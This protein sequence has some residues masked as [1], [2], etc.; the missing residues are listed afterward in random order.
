MKG[1]G[2]ALSTQFRCFSLLCLV[3]FLGKA[4]RGLLKAVVFSCV[5]TGPINNICLNAGEVVRL[6]TCS[7][8]L[9]YNLNLARVDLMT[10]PFQVALNISKDH[11][12]REEFEVLTNITEPIKLEVEGVVDGR[13]KRETAED[14]RESYKRKLNARCRAQLDHVLQRCKEAL[15]EVYDECHRVLP[16]LVRQAQETSRE[17]V[18]QF[19]QEKEK[20]DLT[21]FVLEKMFAFVFIRVIVRAMVYHQNYLKKIDFQNHY[22]GKH[23]LRIDSRRK[24]AG[25]VGVLPL[26]YL[27]SPHYVD[28]DLVECSR[29]EL[30]SILSYSISLIFM[31][32]A[33]TF[34]VLVDNVFYKTLN[35][36][37]KNAQVEFEQQGYHDVNIT[38][39]GS[40]LIA[41]MLR[42]SLE[43]F[44]TQA[45]LNTT[46]SIDQCLPNPSK[47]S[48]WIIAKIYLLFAA[49]VILT[50][51]EA[52]INRLRRF[53]CARFYPKREKQRVLY[54]YNQL[55]RRRKGYFKFLLDRMLQT[56]RRRKYSARLDFLNRLVF[57]YPTCFLWIKLLHRKSCSI[58]EVKKPKRFHDCI[59]YKCFLTYCDECWHDLGET[60][61]I[62][63]EDSNLAHENCAPDH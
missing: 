13:M 32:I 31:I 44:E 60:C 4:G 22:I 49:I 43:G 59:S 29:T 1:L 2:C 50:C 28:L 9:I 45:R 52:I 58:C 17:V 7:A 11:F 33:V 25:K 5:L 24:R 38:V 8:V 6:F 56:L 63:A 40:G 12:I 35:I 14:Y 27:E 55:L 54:L 39:I 48:S 16:I 51:Y 62:C 42:L 23:F 36:V 57:Y 26:R 10:K 20:I 61:P 34:F 37:A 18:L 47:L 46:S 21:V 41:K 19:E 3:A 30:K 53:I 15:K